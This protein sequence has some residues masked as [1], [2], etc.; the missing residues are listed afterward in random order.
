MALIGVPLTYRYHFRRLTWREGAHLPKT[1]PGL[2]AVEYD[3]GTGRHD[4]TLVP[5][6]PTQ[7]D[8][9]PADPNWG[10]HRQ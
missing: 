6:V 2:L 3:S 1:A 8:L 4:G 5:R 9:C 7:T 10:H